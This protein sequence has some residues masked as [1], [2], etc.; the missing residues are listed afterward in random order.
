MI[1]RS[2]LLKYFEDVNVNGITTNHYEVPESVFT[3]EN[4]N[5]LCYCHNVR[6]HDH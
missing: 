1:C 5:N 6:P 3:M 4:P 2:F